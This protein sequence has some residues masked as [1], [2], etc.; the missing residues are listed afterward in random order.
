MPI[1]VAMEIEH[2]IGEL[3]P[4]NMIPEVNLFAS[5]PPIEKALDPV[6]DLLYE[7]RTGISRAAADTR[8]EAP[9]VKRAPEKTRYFFYPE[10]DRVVEVIGDSFVDNSG[11]V[12]KVG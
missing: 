4:T 2:V 11:R 1:K 6:G 7:Q 3:P 8:R 12:V 5:E 10:E 9:M